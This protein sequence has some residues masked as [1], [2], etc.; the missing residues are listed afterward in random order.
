MAT[1]RDHSI[2]WCSQFKPLLTMI[3]SGI[4]N[5]NCT[6]WM[7]LYKRNKQQC[8]LVNS[9]YPR[10]PIAINYFSNKAITVVSSFNS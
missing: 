8:T 5:G 9:Q 1:W 6:L 3:I 7:K 10:Q 4:V 2:L